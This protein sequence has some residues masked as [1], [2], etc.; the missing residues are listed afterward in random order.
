MVAGKYERELRGILSAEE[1]ALEGATK[2]CGDREKKRYFSIDDIPFMV[3]RAGGS[4]GIDLIAVRGEISFPIEVKSSKKDVIYFSDEQRLTEQADDMVRS[5]SESRVL[6]IYAFRL[7]A[8]RG[9]KWRIYTLKIDGLDKK[10]K[11]LQRNIP[12]IQTTTHGN[13]KLVWDEGL[14]LNEFISYIN[15]LLS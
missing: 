8:V 2:T 12:N 7:K 5:C 10:H 13:Y 9:D 6:P 3:V 14:P 11:L 1:E 4:L 15:Y